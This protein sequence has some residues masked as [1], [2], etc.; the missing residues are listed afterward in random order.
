MKALKMLYACVCTY[1]YKCNTAISHFMSV[2]HSWKSDILCEN[3]N[4]EPIYHLMEEIIMHY[5]NPKPPSIF[6]KH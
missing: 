6:L 4:Q 5:N 2:S 1:V 3:L